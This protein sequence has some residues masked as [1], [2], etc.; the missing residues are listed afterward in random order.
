MRRTS[1]VLGL[2]VTGLVASGVASAAPAA[3][4]RAAGAVCAGQVATVVG[5]DR[6]DVL[7]GTA[8]PD[9]IVALGGDDTVRGKGGDDVVCGGPGEDEVSTGPG[10]DTVVAG[11]QDDWVRSQS[12]AD[13]ITGG[14]GNDLVEVRTQPGETGSL[15]GGPGDNLLVLTV[16]DTA[17]PVPVVADQTART[18][19]LGADVEPGAFSGW[20]LAW[21]KGTHAWTYVGSDEVD[22]VISLDGSIAATLLG[23]ADVLAAG[24]GDDRIDGGRG[25]RDTADVQGGTNTCVDVELG[26][27]VGAGEPAAR[28]VREARVALDLRSRR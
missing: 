5:T 9:V 28:L 11:G 25:R 3:P 17:G 8:G 24:D 14:G 18:L 13:R 22:S 4:G 12:G 10:A 19:A 27:C 2:A 23:G 7:T 15:R 6:D 26:D 20:H 1:A 16:V 21:F